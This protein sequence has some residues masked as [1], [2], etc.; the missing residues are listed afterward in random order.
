MYEI[1]V[2]V[3]ARRDA[4]AARRF[5]KRAMSVLK[6]TPGRWSPTPPRSTPACW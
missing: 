3:S 1:D 6:V 5:L 4:D 2:L